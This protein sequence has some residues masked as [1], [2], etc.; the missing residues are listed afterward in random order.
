MDPVATR[1]A[2]VGAVSALWCALHSLLITDRWQRALGRRWPLWPVFGR[3]VYVAGS[4]VSLA[5][6][7]WWLF[8]LPERPLWGWPG[9][10]A[11][12]RGLGLAEAGLLFWL[13][14]RAYD[15]RAFL[16]LGPLRDYALGRPPPPA[17]LRRDG[18]LAVIRHPWYA[19]GLLLC[20]FCLPFSDVNLVW[21]SVF[22][23]YTLLGTELEERRLLR[24]R[25]AEYAEYRRRVPRFCPWPGRRRPG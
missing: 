6:L 8:S 3:L 19:G 22:F 7:G 14:A 5:A 15:G 4:A 17:P 1:L 20:V 12:A 23:L 2:W 24:E 18:I 13:G 10:W 9:P 11:W 21:R 25:G 16:G